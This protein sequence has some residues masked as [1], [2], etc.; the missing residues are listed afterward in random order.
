MIIS[1]EFDSFQ[2]IAEGLRQAEEGA[3]Q[4]SRHR[5]DQKKLWLKMAEVY[6]VSLNAIYKLAE[7]SVVKQ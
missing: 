6:K 5:P 1:S 4:M 2:R 3:K 7:E